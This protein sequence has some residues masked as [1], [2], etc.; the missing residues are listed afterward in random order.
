MKQNFHYYL[1]QGVE[2]TELFFAE[3]GQFRGYF[4]HS[5]YLTSCLLNIRV[6]HRCLSLSVYELIMLLFS[7]CLSLTQ[8]AFKLSVRVDTEILLNLEIFSVSLLQNFA[9]CEGIFINYPLERGDF[10]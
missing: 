3:L 10:L 5:E 7:L 1:N 4:P 8:F 2:E 9:I 6:K